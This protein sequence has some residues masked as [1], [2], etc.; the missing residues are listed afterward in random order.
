[1]VNM[2]F[3]IIWIFTII[4]YIYHIYIF[5]RYMVTLLHIFPPA[6]PRKRPGS[7]P[8]HLQRSHLL[9]AAAD[10]WRAQCGASG[11]APGSSAEVPGDAKK[12][13]GNLWEI[14]GK[15]VKNGGK[16]M[17][18]LCFFFHQWVDGSCR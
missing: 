18:F 12:S 7:P 14:Y 13:G 15:M 9:G 6:G 17:G 2:V 16:S 5:H 8:L 3:I 11:G 1:M 10:G 4:S